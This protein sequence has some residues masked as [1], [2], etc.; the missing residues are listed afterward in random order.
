MS[1]TLKSLIMAN[2]K[3]IGAAFELKKLQTFLFHFVCST[4][5]LSNWFM[6]SKQ[7]FWIGNS[8][9]AT[10]YKAIKYVPEYRSADT[11]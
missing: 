2:S 5:N 6:S 7:Y 8:G 3:P 10:L 9:T 1:K 11:I 4:L